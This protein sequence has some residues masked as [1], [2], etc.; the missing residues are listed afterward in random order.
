MP[1]PTALSQ[2][3]YIERVPHEE[4]SIQSMKSLVGGPKDPKPKLGMLASTVSPRVQ[5]PNN[6]IFTKI[7]TYITTILKPTTLLGPLEPWGMV[8][9]QRCSGALLEMAAGAHGH[10]NKASHARPLEG[11]IQY[12]TASYNIH[13]YIHIYI[14]IYSTI[15][16]YTTVCHNIYIYSLRYYTILYHLYWNGLNY[17]VLDFIVRYFSFLLSLYTAH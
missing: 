12:Y 3:T 14:Y 1:T 4:T 6:H 7:L 8:V 13:I 11:I 5:V 17:T 15:L 2:Q 16:Y 10:A 9:M